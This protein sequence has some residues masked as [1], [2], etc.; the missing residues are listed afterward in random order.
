M[1]IGSKIYRFKTCTN[2]MELAKSHLADAQDGTVFFVETMEHARGR[3]GR[4][5][6]T[7]PGQLL[8]TFILKPSTLK[9][10]SGNELEAQLNYLQMAI[11]LGIIS[12]L[13]PH[14]A[15]LKWPNDIMLGDK[16]MGGIL[17]ELVWVGQ[18]PRGIICG[19]GL[20]VN[21]KFDISDALYNQATSLKSH[22]NK[23]LDR[24]SLLKELLNALN[25]QYQHWK[26]G[27]YTSI[28]ESWIAHQGYLHKKIAVHQKNGSIIEGTMSQIEKN[29]DII[30][31]DSQGTQH[32]ISF[33][34][35]EEVKI[36]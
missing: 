5:W 18:K 23:S 21:N 15:T 33:Y 4:T 34:L 19:F 11:A 30:L 32:Q 7:Y 17:T 35:V 9:T 10:S 26:T 36:T 27:N 14:G 16:K 31:V 13:L 29:G 3:Q 28:F 25:E 8:I 2:S 12:P 1:T 24:E 20:N 22:L 6:S